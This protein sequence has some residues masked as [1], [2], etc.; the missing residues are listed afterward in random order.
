MERM[1]ILIGYNG[2]QCAEA[3]IVDLKARGFHARWLFVKAVVCWPFN[4]TL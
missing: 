1:K 2:S 3:A 4:R